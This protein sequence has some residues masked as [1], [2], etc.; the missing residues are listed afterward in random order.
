M[1]DFFK[2]PAPYVDFAVISLGNEEPDPHRSLSSLERYGF[3]CQVVGDKTTGRTVFVAASGQGVNRD[4][5]GIFGMSGIG[6]QEGR[7]VVPWDGIS[8]ESLEE[9]D[10]ETG[11]YTTFDVRPGLSLV[12]TDLFGYG[13]S[14]ASQHP[15]LAIASNRLHLHKI[16]MAAFSIDIRPNAA[17]VVGSF[18]SEHGFFTQQSALSCTLIDGVRLVPVSVDVEIRDATISYPE[19][20][21]FSWAMNPMG[22]S[23]KDLIEAGVRKIV[24]NAK[25]IAETT[26]FQTAVVDLSGGKDSRLA[27]GAITRVPGW[28]QKARVNTARVPNSEDVEIAAGIVSAYGASYFDGDTVEQYPLTLEDNLRFWRSY[29][30][31]EYHRMAAGAW[32][33][34]G[35]NRSSIQVG[36][37][38]GEIYRS[39]WTTVVDRYLEK[40]QSSE[41]F[42]KT[43][44]SSIAVSGR[45]TVEQL[46]RL[47]T[48]LTDEL[49]SYPSKSIHEKIEDHYMFNRNRSHCGLRGFTFYHDRLT[50][51]PL[52]SADLLAASRSLDYTERA[53]NRVIYDVLKGLDPKLL[54]FRFDGVD[55]PFHAH[56]TE[57][58][59]AV[60]DESTGEWEAAQ[61]AA[62]SKIQSRRA[63]RNQRMAWPALTEYVAREA[64]TALG[65]LRRMDQS[66]R[67]LIP[68]GLEQRLDESMRTPSIG[69]QLASRILAVWDAVRPVE[70]EKN[71][72]QSGEAL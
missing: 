32:S 68:S 9:L 41:E 13:H 31:G 57:Y 43:F 30:F 52:L 24:Y 36:G 3:H 42:V 27:F 40:G 6:M 67:D 17:A 38:N 33:N 2:L 28:D 39:F 51:Y 64:K 22:K 54:S 48:A 69:Y 4:N 11:S 1:T 7:I 47:V 58:R 71:E 59:R 60:T 12:K 45:Y 8:R 61:Q 14:F 70:F 15:G 21:L 44:I 55:D 65:Q 26:L 5:I 34:Q 49:E 23:Y 72:S 29:F 16:V 35:K 56:R 53:S 25:G 46:N 66:T 18:F 63:G 10:P 37:A 50:W 62:A 19:K 20:P